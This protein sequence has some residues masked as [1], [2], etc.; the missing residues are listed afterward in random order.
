MNLQQHFLSG[1]YS[2]RF[3]NY[4]V[5]TGDKRETQ[6]LGLR[7]LHSIVVVGKTMSKTFKS[8]LGNFGRKIM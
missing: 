7:T 3:H 5:S 4:G 8:M 6:S 2:R 1:A